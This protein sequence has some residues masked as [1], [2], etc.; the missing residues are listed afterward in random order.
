MHF[1][2]VLGPFCGCQ[3][4]SNANSLRIGT[5]SLPSRLITKLN[6][7]PRR[8][9]V[10]KKSGTRRNPPQL[11]GTHDWPTPVSINLSIHLISSSRCGHTLLHVERPSVITFPEFWWW[12]FH[13]GA[14]QKDKRP[15]PICIYEY[16]WARPVCWRKEG[17]ILGVR[18]VTKVKPGYIHRL[19]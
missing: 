14:G 6:T 18:H 12:L 5:K 15:A 17:Y 3:V 16:I 13:P 2:F 11:A 7:F 4:G 1:G 10:S 8:I 19:S 9:F